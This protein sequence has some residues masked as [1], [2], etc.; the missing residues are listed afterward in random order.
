MF[1]D[2]YVII[3]NGYDDLAQAMTLLRKSSVIEG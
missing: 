2:S 1:N 3:G